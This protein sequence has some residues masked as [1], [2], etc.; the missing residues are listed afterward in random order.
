ME[1]HCQW[2]T[3]WFTI[4]R[5]PPVEE[6]TLSTTMLEHVCSKQVSS[7]RGFDDD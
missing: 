2:L 5:I 7:F 3:S 4:T 6:D 1:S